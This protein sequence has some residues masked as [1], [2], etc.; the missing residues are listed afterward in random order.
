VANGVRLGCCL[1]KAGGEKYRRKMAGKSI[2]WL[3]ENSA[4]LAENRRRQSG[5]VASACKQSPLAA[6]PSWR[7]CS[8]L[9]LAS[10]HQLSSP[11]LHSLAKW[12]ASRINEKRINEMSSAGAAK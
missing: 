7:V 11:S 4:A 6:R 3:A 12:Q 5:K 1:E 8:G 9:R 2:A 10:H